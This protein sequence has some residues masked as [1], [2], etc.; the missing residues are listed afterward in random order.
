MVAS[1]WFTAPLVAVALLL[2]LD[3]AVAKKPTFRPPSLP[4][5][6]D[7]AACPERCSVSGPSTGNWSV[8]PNFEPIRKCTQTMFYDFSL[9]DSVDDPTVNHRIHACS[10]FGPDFSIIPGSITK[11]AYA[12]PAPAKIRFELGWWNRGYGL[13]APGLRSLVK[14]LRAYI[15]HG[16]G[17]GA[18]DRPFII[19]GQSGQATIGLYIGQGLLSQGLSKSALKILQDNLANSDVSAPSLAIQLCGQGY[20]SSHIFGAMV[21]SNGTFAPIQEAIRTWANA[22]CLSFAGSKEFPGEVMFTTPLLLANGT[23]NSTVRARSLRPYA[24]ECRTVQVEAGDSCGTLAKKCG[25]S[26]ADFTNYNP[27]AS[28]CST[29]KPK[30]H[31]CCSSGTL[32][33]FRPVTNP[34]GSCYSY[35][36][37]SNDNCADLAAEYGLT[38][39]EIESFNK[40]TWGWGGCKVLFL[41]TIMCLSKGAPP[42]PAPISNA[43]CGPQKLGTIPPTDG[44]NIAD[45]NPCPINAC[46]NIWGQC[47]ISKDFCIDTNTGPP[48]TAAPGTYGCISNCGLDIV[49]GKGTGSIKIAYFEGFGLERECLFRDASQI[50]RSKY[51]HV[52]FAFGTLTPT[53]EVNVGDILS[54]YQFTQFKLISGP[55][56]ILSFGGW[57]FSTSKATYSIFRNGVKAEN[58]LTMAKSIANFIKEHDLDGVDID[59]EYPGAPDIPDIPAGEEDE[60]TN[61][62]AFLVVLK[63]LLPGKSISIAAPSSYWYLKQFPIKAISRIVDY[64][65]FMSYDIHGQW[66]AH[67]MWSQDGCVTGN[68]LRSHV[69]LTETRLALVMITKAGVPGE[70]VIVGV[71]S[72]G[73]SFDMAQPGCWSPDCQFTGDRLNSNAKPGRCTGTAGYIS[74]AEIDEIL[75]GGG[76]SGGSSQARAG[77]VVASFVDTSSNTDVLVYDNN[78]WVGYMSEKTKKTRTT[79]YTGWGLGGTTDWAS[80][81]QQY[82]DV[83][84]PAKDWTEFKQLIRA[85]EDP[86]S[87]HSRE[88]DWTKFDCTNPYLVDKTFYTPTQRWKNLDTDAAWRD[89]VRIWKETDKPRN[90]MFTASVSTT[91][92]ISADVDCRNLEDCNTTE[93][94]SAGLNG[95]YSGPAAQF[96]WNSMV[97]IHAMYHNYVLMLERATSLVSMALDDMQKTFAPVPVEEDKAWLYLLIDLITLGT[98]T[99]AGPLYN[100]QLGMYVYFSDKSVD[101]IKD[102]TMTL[103]GQSTTIAK[104]VLSTKQ[105]AWTENLQASFNNMLSRVIEGW[106]NATSLAVNKIFSGSETSLNILWDVM[107]DGKLIEGMPPPGSGP[108]PDPGNIHNEL[109]ANV[110][111]SIYAFAIPNLW[112]VSQT[113]AFILDSGFG[114]DVEK[115]LQDYLEDE[116]ME[117]TGACV[118][119]KRYYLVAPIGESRT[120]DWVNG[121]WDCTLSNKFSAPPGLD[122]LGADFGYL[123]KEDFIKGSIRTWLKNGKRNAGGGMPDVTDIDTINSLIDLDFTTP[124]FIHLPVCS[125]ERAY[126]TWDTSSSGYGANYPCDP[127]PGI[128]NCGDSTFEDQTSA[129]SPKV[130]DCLQIIKNIQDDGKTEWTIQVLG[131][132]QRE[133]AKFGECRFGVEATEQT[134]NADFK[135]GGQDVIDIINDAVEKF[136]G[137]GRVGAKGDM[138]CNGNIKGQAVKWGIY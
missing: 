60:G 92:Y 111:K 103:I 90:I 35:K 70:K 18:A 82:H 135:V 9:Y 62:L 20:G 33:D 127:P 112:R 36:V 80:D 23:A 26:G 115:P 46:C 32:P 110:K 7:D 48:G 88:G 89:V 28:F 74:N 10:S 137:S 49:K 64:I 19:Y 109:Q 93:E 53:Y 51:T 136:G 133:I 5:Y 123:T 87:D 45:L 29:L 37:K 59:W 2:S 117:A 14:Q 116:T 95:P 85:G 108:P 11:T 100:R 21:T 121:M 40:N 65:V 86:K 57:D 124:G 43:I 1:S 119:G 91:L 102:T 99:V 22:T 25:I 69:N 97:K 73:R 13:A 6:D 98:L 76:S 75:A 96:I 39:D 101:D 130:E 58:R 3:G 84:G 125:P 83:P 126:Q 44:S 134:G 47:G 79:L 104:D 52:H 118:D 41:D 113:F 120:C 128:N 50:D 94:C 34:D 54:S 16:H 138:S 131:K 129:A 61:Y 24:A 30:Q 66:D 55:K 105:E 78:Q 17:D 72:Y 106:Q 107:S 8:Y 56:K 38:V 81:L 63:N 42:F 68:C 122:R 77:R 12:S 132:N 4:T 67:N 27:G 71:T 15:D 114:C 31:V